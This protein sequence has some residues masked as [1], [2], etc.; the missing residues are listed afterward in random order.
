MFRSGQIPQAVRTS[1]VQILTPS[2]EI[3]SIL[4]VSFPVKTEK[5]FRIGAVVRDITER[6]QAEEEIRKLNA[7]LEQRVE[8]RTNELQAANKELETFVY[9]VSHDL[10]APL[11][12]MDGFARILQ[13]DYADQLDAEGQRYLQHVRFSSQRMSELVDDL[14]KLSRLARSEIVP[15]LVDLSRLAQ[16]VAEVL[17]QAAPERIVDF[18]ILPGMKAYGDERLLRIVLENLIGNAHKFTAGHASARIEVGQ[19]EKDGETVYFIRDDGAGFDMAYAAKLFGAFQRLHSPSQFEGNGIG[20]ATV[21]RI[22]LR[23][24]GKVWA[25]SAV[26]QGATFYFTLPMKSQI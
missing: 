13:E 4:Q 16:S 21:Q 23:H 8:Q 14:L 15:G 19:L 11:R 17:Q 18:S 6:K 2:G 24:G 12:R 10:R 7:E 22:I 20:L 5:G 3:K 9:S 25:E 1:E 26:E